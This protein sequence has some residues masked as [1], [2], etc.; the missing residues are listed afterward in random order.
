M[1]N[2]DFVRG[3]PGLDKDCQEA[4]AWLCENGEG[5]PI[6]SYTPPL[7]GTTKVEEPKSFIALSFRLGRKSLHGNGTKVVG[8]QACLSTTQPSIT[9]TGTVVSIATALTQHVI[10][11]ANAS[12]IIVTSGKDRTILDSF[13]ETIGPSLLSM[14]YT[15]QPFL[16]SGSV[17][18]IKIRKG[19]RS[20]SLVYYENLTGLDPATAVSTGLALA[21][22]ADS[23]SSDHRMLAQDLYRATAA[24]SEWLHESFGV[25][26]RPTA[27]MIAMACARRFLDPQL[28][29]WRPS[30]VV[31]AM[32]RKGLGYRSGITYG[33]RYRGQ[34]WKIDVNRQ[35]T[36]ALRGRLPLRGFFGKYRRG[37]SGLFVCRVSSDVSISYPM[38]VWIGSGF[39]Y[40]TA[41]R[42]A[43]VSILHTEEFDCMRSIGFEIEPSIGY[44]F[45]HHFTLDTYVQHLQNILDTF[46]KESP[47]GKLCKPLGNF[48]YGK[49][50]QDPHQ[51]EIAFSEKRPAG[52]GEK[53]WRPYWDAEGVRWPTIWERATVR[54]TASQHVDIAG[55]IAS[56][57]RSQTVGMWRFLSESLGATVVRAHTDSLTLDVDPSAYV[58]MSQDSIGS[59][60]LESD[61]EETIIVGPNAFFDHDGAHI[62]GVSQPTY[63]MVE[64]MYDGNVVYV[65]QEQNAPRRGLQREATEVRREYRATGSV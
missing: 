64:R 18:W 55:V 14:K 40:H 58:E 3:I 29:K 39:A 49:F 41:H 56:M 65:T 63:E 42:G 52:T 30:P 47:Q 54:V 11:S 33:K 44:V 15:L 48:V 46:G 1:L 7:R 27:G 20:W 16:M 6:G 31:V 5:Y 22:A 28:R 25:A 9:I 50:A 32:E 34:T 36:A 43:F 4:M 24:Y 23:E 59:W 62:S 2:G 10:T 21:K 8:F 45:T 12:N 61:G 13:L 35:Y 53:T 38:G 19:K 60:R 57:A 51:L 37:C 17:S 26:M